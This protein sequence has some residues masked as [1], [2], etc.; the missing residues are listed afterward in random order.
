MPMPVEH[1]IPLGGC[2]RR[3]WGQGKVAPP[4]SADTLHCTRGQKGVWCSGN[5]AGDT[6]SPGL[7]LEKVSLVRY[8][9]LG[10]VHVIAHVIDDSPLGTEWIRSGIGPTHSGPEWLARRR[11]V[12]HLAS[13]CAGAP[14]GGC[15][16]CERT[17]Q[18]PLRGEVTSSGELPPQDACILNMSLAA[19][20]PH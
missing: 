15:I 10:G 14:A 13:W 5:Y 19:A 1:P 8:I 3:P 16:S 7:F 11:S 18:R 20:Q 2:R 4:H 6:G 9:T 17:L 12:C